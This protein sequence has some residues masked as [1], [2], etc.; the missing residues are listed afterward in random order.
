MSLL[1]LLSSVVTFAFGVTM[2]DSAVTVAPQKLESP[3][4]PLIA[5]SPG[6]VVLAKP[7]FILL[8]RRYFG[9]E[10]MRF[11]KTTD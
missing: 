10:P 5:P 4:C 8:T 6:A 7:Q 9:H 1:F 3:H 11:T 2:F